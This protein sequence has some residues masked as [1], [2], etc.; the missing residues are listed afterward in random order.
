[1]ESAFGVDRTNYFASLA[2]QIGLKGSDLTS[3]L[4]DASI[5]KK[6]DFDTA[7]GKKAGITGTPRFISMEKKL[8]IRMSKMVS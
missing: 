6:I 5:K 3:R 8:A 7:L 4:D 1:M 2:D